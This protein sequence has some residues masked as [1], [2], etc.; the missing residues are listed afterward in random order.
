[1]F[2]QFYIHNDVGSI[3]KYL[4]TLHCVGL[5]VDAVKLWLYVAVNV[6]LSANAMSFN[7][8]YLKCIWNDNH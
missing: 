8:L 4:N 5:S 7:F 2:S 3:F 1:M 6:I